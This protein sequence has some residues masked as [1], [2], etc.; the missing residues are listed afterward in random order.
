MVQETYDSNPIIR[1]ACAKHLADHAAFIAVDIEAAKKRYS[2][3]AGW[4]VESLSSFMQAQIQGA[5]I[6]AKAKQSPQIAIDCL[7]HLKRYLETL[8]SH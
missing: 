2:P 6:L 7:Q 8:F 3:A 4:S 5:F 1:D